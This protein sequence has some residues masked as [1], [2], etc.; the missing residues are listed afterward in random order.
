DKE[1]RRKER[2]N[3]HKETQQCNVIELTDSDTSFELPDLLSPIVKRPKPSQK[4]IPATEEY[5][6]LYIDTS[7][8][9]D[10]RD[11][12]ILILNDPPG[13]RRPLRTISPTMHVQRCFPTD[14]TVSR[15]SA[16]GRVVDTPSAPAYT[17]SRRMASS[18]NSPSKHCRTSKKAREAEEQARREKYAADLFTE[19]NH[20]VFDGRLPKETKLEWSK[21][22]LTTAGRARWHR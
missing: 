4:T 3:K 19:L 12:A 7:D 18:N 16:T 13:S 15:S 22:L 21:R 8:D 17:P 20:N 5:I 6:P 2:S 9:D 14:E 11:G 10:P 1:L